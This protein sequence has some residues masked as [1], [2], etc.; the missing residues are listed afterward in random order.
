MEE[1]NIQGN[2]SNP[3]KIV[4]FILIGIFLVFV[5]IFLIYFLNISD[6]QKLVHENNKEM[7]NP[8]VL[9]EVSNNNEKK[10]NVFKQSSEVTKQNDKLNEVGFDK[11]PADDPLLREDIKVKY[12]KQIDDYPKKIEFGSG[13]DIESNAVSGSGITGNVISNIPSEGIE[14]QAINFFERYSGVLGINTDELKVKTKEGS[15]NFETIS[16]EQNY[17]DVPVYL[18]KTS[19]AKSGNRWSL[20]VSNYLHDI[21]LDVN[22]TINENDAI[23]NAKEYMGLTSDPIKDLELFVYPSFEGKVIP[24]LVYKIDFPVVQIESN[25]QGRGNFRREQYIETFLKNYPVND[26]K[27]ILV[28]DKRYLKEESSKKGISGNS[29]LN[30]FSQFSVFVD[31]HSGEIADIIDNIREID[32]SGRSFGKVFP[33]HYQQEK[34]KVKVNLSNQNIYNKGNEVLTDSEG[35]YLFEDFAGGDIGAKFTGPYI[36]VVDYNNNEEYSFSINSDETNDFDFSELDDSYKQEATNMFYH[37]NLIHDFYTTG[38]YPYNIE[39]LNFQMIAEINDAPNCNAWANGATIHFFQ[40]VENQCEALSLS[41]DVIYHEYTHNMVK[42]LAPTLSNVYRGHTGNMNEAYADYF[43]CSINDDPCLSDNLWFDKDCLRSCDNNQKF[44]RD[45]NPEP[46]TASMTISGSIWD[47]REQVGQEIADTLALLALDYDP[48]T[49]QELADNFIIVDD[50]F[51]GDGDLS[52]GAPHGEEICNS[53]Y[54]NHG[55]YSDYCENIL[56]LISILKDFNKEEYGLINISG[57]AAGTDFKNYSVYYKDTGEWNEIITSSSKVNDILV[58]NF[59]TSIFKD[60]TNAIKLIT[61]DIYGNSF[62]FIKGININNLEITSLDYRDLDKRKK[63]KKVFGKEVI[64]INGSIRYPDLDSYEIKY[65][66]PFNVRYP[67]LDSYE[68]KYSGPFNELVSLTGVVNVNGP[69]EDSNLA[70]FD[71]RGFLPEESGYYDLEIFING[72]DTPSYSFS[73]LVDSMLKENWPKRTFKIENNWRENL[74]WPVVADLNKDGYKEII[75]NQFANGKPIEVDVWDVNGNLLPGWPFFT[76]NTEEDLPYSPEAQTFAIDDVNGDGFDEVIILVQ[77]IERM[78]VY[79]V[80]YKGDVVKNFTVNYTEGPEMEMYRGSLK[81][82]D[83]NNDGRKEFIISTT[84]KYVYV[85]DIDGNLLPGWP[86]AIDFSNS[87]YTIPFKKN[88]VAIADIDND[89][90]N[91][92]IRGFPDYSVDSENSEDY[93]VVYA[94][95][96]D[97]SIVS[98]WP[99]QTNGTIS[100]SPAIGDVDNDGDLEVVVGSY[101]D[102][103]GY[104]YVFNHDGI[105]LDGWP[106][107]LDSDIWASP[108]FIWASP[109]LFDADNNRDLEI[110]AF[111]VIGYG[112]S[113]NSYL[114]HHNGENY[115]RWPRQIHVG[116]SSYSEPLAADIDNDGELEIIGAVADYVFAYNLDGTFATN[117]PRYMDYRLQNSITTLDD[118]DN[119]NKLELISGSEYGEIFV[120]DL[121]SYIN[122]EKMD[123]S[124]FMHDKELTGCYNCDKTTTPQPSR[125]QSKLTNNEDFDVIGNLTMILQKNISGNWVDERKVFNNFKI[126]IPAN[127]LIKLDKAWNAI[128]VVADSVGQYRVYARFEVPETRQ[129]VENS[130]EFEVE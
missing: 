87:W 41:S 48:Q 57:V 28:N 127:G 45:Y 70:Q 89:G 95:N 107:V 112:K 97:G 74:R 82:A 10:S 62:E 61:R 71:T 33:D 52:N 20:F 53:F 123:W 29:S 9:S 51:Y 2:Y 60:G 12:N 19:I 93:G 98:G 15:R 84:W 115:N 126:I 94:W 108:I 113:N 38:D 34:I 109:I 67:D 125:P 119:D 66:G 30:T 7:I 114:F 31:A 25:M 78:S 50:A 73:I 111:A 129:V 122:P 75:I 100:S 49:F 102:S 101:K 56:S 27:N 24:K 121:E 80:D 54:T 91:E 69:I 90:E 3:F 5:G 1:N 37:A 65:S 104:L 23:K 117:F 14:E 96:V 85:L 17:K 39:G 124:R 116:G 130:W 106:Q 118:I 8:S 46:H 36:K 4:S 68:I 40:A 83:L 128:R 21:N 103:E 86:Q 13:L 55:V 18:S 44:P 63:G 64:D 81:F 77:G 110:F 32:F 76:P 105:L 79:A 59:D 22:P 58:Y 47:L 43:A 35:Q 92:I 88:N 26:F 120:W 99:Q 42:V 16:F 72:E 6:Q 11:L